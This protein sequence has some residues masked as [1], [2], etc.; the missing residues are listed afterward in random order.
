MCSKK[1]FKCLFSMIFPS[2]NCRKSKQCDTN[3]YQPSTCR[4]KDRLKCCNRDI[5]T[6]QHFSCRICHSQYSRRSDGKTGN[7]TYNNR[8][9]ESTCHIYVSLT[10]RIICSSRR[11]CDR[12]RSHTSFIGK[13]STGNTK[14]H[15]T[16]HGSYNRTT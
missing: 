5:R 14:S 15:C 2:Q 12:C 10:N 11:S 13:Y 7:R 6:G 4:T 3:C 1:I 16:H 9:P 8:I